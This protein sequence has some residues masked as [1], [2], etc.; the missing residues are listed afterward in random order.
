MVDWLVCPSVWFPVEHICHYV[1]SLHVLLITFPWGFLKNSKDMEVNYSICM[2]GGLS[3]WWTP[4]L[5]SPWHG[6]T[7]STWVVKDQRR[8]ECCSFHWLAIRHSER[9]VSDVARPRYCSEW[10]VHV[11]WMKPEC[12]GEI[13]QMGELM[14]DVSDRESWWEVQLFMMQQ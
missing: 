4:G 11:E 5:S 3:L 9:Y 2:N 12:T 10:Q 14:M 8:S 13:Q 7:E 1:W 6:D